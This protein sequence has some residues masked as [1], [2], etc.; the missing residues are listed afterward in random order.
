MYT[1]IP[2]HV[3]LYTNNSREKCKQTQIVSMCIK[4]YNMIM[5]KLIF[6]VYL[7]KNSKENNLASLLPNTI[8]QVVRS[9]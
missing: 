4:L 5:I 8:G 1:P 2:T 9:C 7:K 6:E 3:G